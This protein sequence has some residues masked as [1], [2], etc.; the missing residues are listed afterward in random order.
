MLHNSFL[1][2]DCSYTDVYV[3]AHNPLTVPMVVREVDMVITWEG[4]AS[5][6]YAPEY[7]AV[8]ASA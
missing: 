3:F 4:D 5:R 1:S 2:R 8:S 6:G 7:F